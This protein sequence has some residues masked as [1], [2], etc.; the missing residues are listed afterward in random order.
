VAGFSDRLRALRAEKGMKQA[1]L[2][3]A[4]GVS[5]SA[6]SYWESGR[7]VPHLDTIQQLA[8]HFGVSMD[9]MLG[10]TDYR[11][12]EVPAETISEPLAILM[13]GDLK[14]LPPD[15]RRTRPRM[16]TEGGRIYWQTLY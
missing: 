16:A 9:Y 1:E 2:G 13:R 3:T 4:L 15:A 12:V 10:K 7:G 6:V 5:A 14:R 11:K 8:D